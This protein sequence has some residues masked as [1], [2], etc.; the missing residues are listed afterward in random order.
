M[1]ILASYH[2]FTM[3][4]DH[5]ILQ[6]VRQG[7]CTVE[8]R[9]FFHTGWQIKVI[10]LHSTLTKLGPLF[11]LRLANSAFAG[12]TGSLHLDGGEESTSLELAAGRISVTDAPAGEHT[13]RAGPALGRL[14]I[15]SDD[16]V[17]IFRQEEM[18]C[19][20][21]A[22]EIAMVL[23]PNLHPMMSHWDEF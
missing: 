17:E 11:E 19:T 9:Y 10:N 4:K 8:D 12:W 7:P 18:T 15:G 21:L 1:E 3:P 20:G 6:I 13:L 23:F 16:P 2:F 14:L 5:P 22:G